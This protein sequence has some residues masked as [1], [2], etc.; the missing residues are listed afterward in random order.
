MESIFEPVPK[1]WK[2]KPYFDYYYYTIKTK[3][4][5]N[6]HIDITELIHEI[7][8]R[9]LKFYPTFLY[10]IM[11]II[12]QNEEFRISFDEKGVLG[13]WNYVNPSYTIFH[14]DDETFSDIWSEYKPSFREF[15]EEIINDMNTYKDV[16]KIKAK[17]NRP[18]NFCPVSSLP[19]LSFDSFSHDTFSESLL[20]YPMIRFGKFYAKEDKIL[21]PLSVFV[22]HAVADGYHTCRLINEIEDL[23][24]RVGEWIDA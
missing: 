12:N 21:L 18:P 22:N 23:G 8:K 13:I 4:N 14:K 6:Y 3:Y 7:K 15:Y 19:W 2:R 20:L 5:I 17:E 24:K 10:V 1:D 9:N 16:K 11:R